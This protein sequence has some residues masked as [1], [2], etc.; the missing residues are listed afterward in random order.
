MQTTIPGFPRIGKNRELKFL[1]EK[2]FKKEIDE[3][4]YLNEVDKINQDNLLFMKK[5]ID[6]VPVND[7]SLYDNMLDMMWALGVVEKKYIENDLE[8]V[9]KYFSIARGA[10]NDKID[11]KPY[12]MKKWFNTNY[13]YI[14][15]RINK[16]LYLKTDFFFIENNI[17]NAE[18]LNIDFK[19]VLIGPYTFLKLSKKET[20]DKKVIEKILINYK[21]LFKKLE[22]L[23]VKI[24]QL[25][26]PAVCYNANKKDLFLFK[27]IYE[28]ILEK[29]PNFYIYFQTYFSYI[30]KEFLNEIIKFKMDGLGLDFVE[31]KE[32]IKIIKNI[33]LKDKKIVA[34]VVNGK[35]IWINNYTESLDILNDLIEYAGDDNILVSASCSLLFVPYTKETEDKIKNE[36]LKF[37][38][39]AK[40][41]LIELNEL[42]KLAR[43]KNFKRNNKFKKN[44]KIINLLFKISKS[45]EN[46]EIID[47]IKLKNLKRKSD[48]LE[49]RKIQDEYLNLPLLP[50]TTIGSFPQTTD[51]RKI[52]KDFKEGKIKKEEYDNYIKEKIKELIKFQEEIN[53]DV[54]VHGEFERNDMV[55]YF[56]EN[57]KGFLIT[58][59]GWVQSY[60]TR[61][62][63]P[64]IIFSYIKRVKPITVDYIKFAQSLTEKPVKAILTGPITI[65]NWSFPNEFLN[66]KDIALSIGEALREEINDLI[67]NG[68]KIIQV[69]EAALREKLPLK[70]EKHKEYLN[71]AV[72]SFKYCV[73]DVP[74]KIQVHTHMCYSEFKD[75]VDYIEK[76]DVDVISIEAARSDF[77]I[78][79]FLKNYAKK[80]QI[81]P[82]IYDIHSPRI[83]DV[84]ELTKKI[85]LL[86]KFVPEKNLWIN[87]DCGLKTRNWEE[88]KLSLKNMVVAGQKNR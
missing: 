77:S 85:K 88:V 64:P 80:R 47:R 87:P 61:A 43:N 83:P 58:K 60:G 40:E 39:F 57:L 69:D 31:G 63:K 10:K 8:K 27:R 38:S 68:I 6:L 11:L 54:L 26:E 59:N 18:K 74:D 46:N 79:K 44:Q 22:E 34:G 32:N 37:I 7:F 50:T 41:K 3:R 82:G 42:K 86:L 72:D 1:T 52:R 29:K 5:H 21:Q 45:N 25:D 48:V 67:K 71:I 78:L 75:I 55:E 73:K 33:K 76:M 65:I 70:K 49:R 13:H 9:E 84:E 24:V 20:S 53:L 30:D 14:V 4:N 2:F 16:N 12:D 81:G 28:N 51:L 35:N 23:K 66:M 15:P 62:T 19:V 36:K 17:K 56:A